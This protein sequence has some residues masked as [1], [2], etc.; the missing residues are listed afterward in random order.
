MRI[1]LLA[2]IACTSF[3]VSVKVQHLNDFWVHSDYEVSKRILGSPSSVIVEND[4]FHETA[5]STIEKSVI[6][7]SLNV[8]LEY[9]RQGAVYDESRISFISSN[10][11]VIKISGSVA[12][13]VTSGEAEI[14]TYLDDHLLIKR[15]V[16]TTEVLT[17]DVQYGYIRAAKGTLARHIDDFARDRIEPLIDAGLVASPINGVQYNDVLNIFSKWN[18][19]GEFDR[20]TN[21][22][23]YGPDYTGYPAYRGM[24]AGTDYPPGS[25]YSRTYGEGAFVAPLLTPRHSTGAGHVGWQIGTALNFIDNNGNVVTRTIIAQYIP[26]NT[27]QRY[28]LLNE[29]VPVTI[30]PWPVG[31]AA[32]DYFTEP[33]NLVAYDVSAQTYTDKVTG[34]S[35]PTEQRNGL[36]MGVPFFR[37]NQ[38]NDMS[39]Y[40]MGMA[41]QPNPDEGNSSVFIHT[42]RNASPIYDNFSDSE[43]FYRPGDVHYEFFSEAPLNPGSEFSPYGYGA[44]LVGGDSGT[45]AHWVINGEAVA[46]GRSDG[47]I[48]LTA[49][50][51]N[52][53][54]K[55]V[56]QVAG[57][58]SYDASG[59]WSSW[60]NDGSH[61]KVAYP[62]L[63]MF[64]NFETKNFVIADDT[65]ALS[66]IADKWSGLYTET[67]TPTT[68][69]R[70]ASERDL[71]RFR[72]FYDNGVWNFESQTRV[73]YSENWPTGW[74]Y[75]AEG[76]GSAS[77]PAEADFQ[78]IELTINN[79]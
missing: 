51:L 41:L 28:F 63:S 72:F 23:A 17:D 52:E 38:F 74:N 46:A 56:D 12:E 27:D 66:G 29:D 22:W 2:L 57:V 67:V 77:S 76:A 21:M 60:P 54:I 78:I 37:R 26:P 3:A 9:V 70:A 14:F 32:L 47:T 79:P 65:G 30:K 64:P 43:E 10:P 25:I 55:R 33:E 44:P 75:V 48:V 8:E 19:G 61:Y 4:G 59:N 1:T 53:M 39:L 40:R 15:Q 16:V 69:V 71:E 73:S 18:E 49:E 68:W 5:Y 6:D 42:H 31:Y 58:T 45:W 13:H 11:D 34:W 50:D 62:D 35:F 36:V 7:Y 20:N 24:N